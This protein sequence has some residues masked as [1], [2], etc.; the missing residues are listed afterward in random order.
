MIVVEIQNGNF[1]FDLIDLGDGLPSLVAV[2]KEI[3]AQLGWG[4]AEAVPAARMAIE[5]A[6]NGESITFSSIKIS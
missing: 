4:L 3:R 5:F 6:Q 1:T 2:A